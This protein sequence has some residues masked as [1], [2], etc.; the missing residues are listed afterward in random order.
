MSER[1]QHRR[2]YSLVPEEDVVLFSVNSQTHFKGR[3]LDLSHGGALIYSSDEIIAVDVRCPYKLYLE[4]RGQMFCLEGTLVRSNMQ[5]FAFRFVNVT[6]VDATELR[7]KLA[8]M[9]MMAARA[10]G[11]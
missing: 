6:P 2:V 5:F 8:R 7:A 10:A 4:S 11:D 3:L 9:E 1:R